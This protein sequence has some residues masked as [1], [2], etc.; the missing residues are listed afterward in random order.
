MQGGDG[1]VTARSGD[2]QDI[3]SGYSQDIEVRGRSE[4]IEW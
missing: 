2:G 4:V 3:E 1:S